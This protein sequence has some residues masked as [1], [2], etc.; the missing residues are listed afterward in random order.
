[1]H[2]LL[3]ST[4]FCWN[5]A[6]PVHLNM[7]C[8]H[9]STAKLN[10]SNR[11]HRAHKSEGI[12]WLFTE[13]RMSL[14]ILFFVNHGKCSRTVTCTQMKLGLTEVGW[15]SH[16]H[17]SG[18]HDT[19]Q[20][21]GCQHSVPTYQVMPPPHGCLTRTIY[22]SRLTKRNL[23]TSVWKVHPYEGILGRP[24]DHDQ[25]QTG[26]TA[27]IQWMEKVGYKTSCSWDFLLNTPHVVFVL[28]AKK[29]FENYRKW[30]EKTNLQRE[31][32]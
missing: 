30:L 13:Y 22:M 6:R 26:N 21:T 23:G 24:T 5:T 28:P 31:R 27:M 18:G 2:C 14:L 29:P 3:G 7:A 19:T 10:S 9:T 11:G 12:L 16:D 17:S 15:L 4:R 25:H 32:I 20:I 1:M 8:F